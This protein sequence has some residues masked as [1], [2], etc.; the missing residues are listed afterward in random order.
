MLI[1]GVIE[2]TRMLANKTK[3]AF[4]ILIIKLLLLDFVTLKLADILFLAKN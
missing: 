3:M 4:D 1:P 2:N